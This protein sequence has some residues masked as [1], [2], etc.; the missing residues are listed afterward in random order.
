MKLREQMPALE[1]ATEVLNS[2]VKREELIGKSQH[3]F[4]FGL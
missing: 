2:A 4:T 1:G 3:L